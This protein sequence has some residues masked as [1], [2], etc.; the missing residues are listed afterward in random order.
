MT[1]AFKQISIIKDLRTQVP[2]MGPHMFPIKK[3]VHL[4]MEYQQ[5][6]III[7]GKNC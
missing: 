5:R 4:N 3:N 7:D 6:Y 1:M 2:T